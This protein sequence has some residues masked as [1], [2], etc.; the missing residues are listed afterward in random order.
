[1]V[2]STL[3]RAVRAARSS[4]MLAGYWGRLGYGATMSTLSHLARPSYVEEAVPGAVDLESA[5]RIAVMIHYDSG[6]VVH[7]YVHY[8]LA[9]LQDV[10]FATIFVTN[11]PAP[12][13]PDRDRVLRVCARLIRRR[14]VGYDFGGWKEGIAA[15]P[16]LTR[17]DQLLIANDSVYGPFH[18]VGDLV[19]RMSP[20]EADVW[21][22]TDSWDRR[23]HL[24]S[25]FML[26]HGAALQAPG[27]A[28]F[29]RRLRYI[30][31]KTWVIRR[32]EIG[33]TRAMLAANLRVKALYPYRMCAAA[34]AD[35]VIQHGALGDQ[36]DATRQDYIR[37]LYRLI[38]A[39]RPVNSTH[40][41]WDYL[42]ANMGFPFIKR[43]LLQR[44]PAHIPLLTY[45]ERV[46]RENSIYDTSLITRH[47]EMRNKNR[48]F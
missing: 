15:V 24:Q 22:M 6:G 9:Q 8:Y 48:V 21:G 41:F 13:A 35:A 14:N 36:V 42:I 43:E 31:S 3:D 12:S 16:D 2:V 25:Y 4:A 28:D 17:L 34:L 45:W 20:M 7:E 32:Y 10:G 30:Q 37:M 38:I 5:R 33:L 39:G 27:F 11:G 46:V 47:L 29:W 26:F 23:Y 18:H 44:N 1:M 40:F 19:D